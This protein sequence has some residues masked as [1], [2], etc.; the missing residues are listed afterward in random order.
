VSRKSDLFLN[1]ERMWREMDELMGEPWAGEGRT[2]VSRQQS[3]FSPRVDVYYC[4]REEPR[5]VVL[6]ELAGVDADSVSLEVAGRELIVSG[7]RAI[8]ETEGRVYQQVEIEAGAF[9]RIVELGADVV[10]DRAQASYDDGILRVELP[11][12]TAQATTR[13]PIEGGEANDGD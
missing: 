8:Q 10:A 12:R 3:G 7:E 4:N 2:R 9:R 5:A 1:L 6:V 13:V 11:L